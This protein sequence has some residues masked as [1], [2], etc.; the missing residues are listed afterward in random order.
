MDE[1]THA[2]ICVV[3]LDTGN[4]FLTQ[5]AF[6]PTDA[7]DVQ[8]TFEFPGG[9]LQPGETPQGAAIREFAEEVGGPP[10]VF[11]SAGSWTSSPYQG[12]IC[13]IEAQPDMSDWRATDEVQAVVWASPEDAIKMNL[14]PEMESFDW[15]LVT[16]L[17]VSGN[18]DGAEGEMGASMDEPNYED[19]TLDFAVHSIPIHG[20]VAP[21]ETESGDARAFSGGSMTSRPLRLPFS[22]QKKAYNQHDGSVVVGSVDRLMRKDGLVHWEGQLLCSDEGDELAQL[23]AF[24]GRYGVSVDGDRGSLDETRSKQ[25]GVTWFEAVRAAGLTAV[26]IPAFAEAYVAFGP[27]PDMPDESSEDGSILVAGA[28][29]P[30]TF[31]RGAGWVT[32]PKETSRIHEYWMPGHPGGEKIQ[33]GK[34]GD[35]A[36]AKALIGEKIAKHSPDKMRFLNQIIAQWH[37]DALGYW[38]ATHARMYREGK[39]T[40]AGFDTGDSW[41][42]VM[43]ASISEEAWDGDQS[44]FTL[45]QWKKSCVL[46]RGGDGTTYAQYGFPIREPNGDLSRA[47]VHNAAARIDQAKAPSAAIGKAKAALRDAYAE[48]NE[49]APDS[50]KASLD[51]A[52]WDTNSVMV[53]SAVTTLPSRSRFDR[54]EGSG[55]LVIETGED[56]LQYTYGYLGEWGVCHIGYDGECAGLPDDPTGDGYAEFHLG[57][58]Q[59][60]EGYIS[61]GLITYKVNHR[62]ASQLLS[63]TAEQAH[64]DNV[65]N[66]WAAVRL[67]EDERGVWFAGVVLPGVPQEDV[68]LIEASGQISG[69]WKYGALRGLQSVNIPG[70]PVLRSSAVRS[71]SGE[72]LALVASASGK[73]C[74]PSPVEMMQA[75]AQADAE[76][77]FQKLRDDYTK[78]L[79]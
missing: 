53:A 5:R 30:E 79:S 24:F 56:G 32:N 76:A 71:D 6:D 28:R 27:H 25:T 36:R 44:R 16:G 62:S 10:W 39:G 11:T 9:G 17:D 15:S 29:S 63:E 47:A 61:T 26:A 13:T 31:D 78:G 77:R 2:G 64:Y 45:G 57:R 48:L 12:F 18:T 7:P 34:P 46:D 40:K 59:T 75:L 19:C 14:R 52:L 22:W 4:V 35:F 68:V 58:T 54:Q 49:D 73:P 23:I 66:A 20:V 38:P 67:G 50:V 74:A 55:A 1:I 8:E 37:F 72:I 69:E 33:W 51:E 41:S 65:A 43:V 60:D 3:A 21:E 42:E 70:F